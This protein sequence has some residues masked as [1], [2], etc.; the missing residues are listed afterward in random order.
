VDDRETIRIAL[1]FCRAQGRDT[2]DY[3]VASV[4]QG[5]EG[6]VSVLFQGKS[7]QPGDHFTVWVDS[8]AGKAVSLIPGR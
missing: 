4:R 8:A 5:E 6:Q 3:E 2:G 7:G 1:E